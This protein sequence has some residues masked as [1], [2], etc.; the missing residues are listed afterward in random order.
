MRIGHGYD[1]HR[2]GPGH[3]LVLG[4]VAFPI[5]RGLEAHS[6]GDVLIHAVCDALLGALGRAISGAFSRHRPGQ[7]GY[8]QPCSVASGGAAGARS[9]LGAGNMD[10]TL[11]AQ[12]PQMAPHIAPCVR[13]WRRIWHECGTGEC[14]GHHHG[15]AGLCRPR[16]GYRRP[17]GGAAASRRAMMQ[18]GP[19]PGA[20]CRQRS[21]SLQPGRFSGQ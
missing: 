7:C 3:A 12:A 6:D 15:E 10:A 11:I 20:P 16:G 17:R 1:V 13:T 19:G 14:E 21:D 5:D 4:G 18:P 2:F 8:R 9:G